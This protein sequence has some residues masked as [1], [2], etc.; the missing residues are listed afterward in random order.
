MEPG[1][2]L[3]TTKRLGLDAALALRSTFFKGALD[4]LYLA[5]VQKTGSQWFKAVLSDDR[6]RRYSKL[7]PYPQRRYE[8]NEF[9]RRFPKGVLVPGLYMSYDLYEE[10][11]KPDNYRTICVIRDP[12]DIIV[13]WYWSMRDTH[14]EMGKVP[15]YRAA[16]QTRDLDDGLHYCIDAFHMKLASMR[17][18]ILNKEDPNV[19][20]VRFEDMK[21]NPVHVMREIMDFSGVG[22]PDHVIRDTLEDYTKEKM[23]AADLQNRGTGEESHYRKSGSDHRQLFNDEHYRHFYASTGNLVE[24]LGYKRA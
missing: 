7:L 12:R 10:I 20:I 14:E 15:K 24:I 11:E 18:W 19:R 5:G 1:K 17:T 16:L 6:I 13:S 22:V 23:R 4:N 9:K 2:L 21:S 8:Y 3:K